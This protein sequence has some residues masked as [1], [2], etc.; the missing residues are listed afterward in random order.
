MDLTTSLFD[1]RHT[2]AAPLLAS[3]NWPWQALPGIGDFI[4]Q[5]AP[6][7]PPTYQQIAPGVWV[8]EHTHIEKT[9]LIQGPAIIGSHCQVRHAAFV[10]ENVIIGDH[11]VVGN[12][13]EIKNAILFDGAQAPHFNYIGDAILGHRAHMGAGAILSN[14]K[15][16]GDEV[17]VVLDGQKQG[18]G[19]NKFGALVGDFAEIGCNAVLFPGT[20]AG[21]HCVIY[22]LCPARGFIPQGYI[23]KNDGRLYPKEER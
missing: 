16:S 17:H 11:C 9:A 22:P 3:V 7:L 1:L 21:R 8:G 20:I 13:T 18:T 12:S 4:Q 19:L 14:F 6:Q 10:R 15:S 23:L 5:L 2:L